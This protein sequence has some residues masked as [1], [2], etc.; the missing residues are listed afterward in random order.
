M[1]LGKG[2]GRYETARWKVF[3]N[4]LDAWGGRVAAKPQRGLLGWWNL[5]PEVDFTE[6]EMFWFLFCIAKQIGL[7]GVVVTYILRVVTRSIQ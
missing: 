2:R 4:M 1:G 7:V 6:R 3:D 5:L